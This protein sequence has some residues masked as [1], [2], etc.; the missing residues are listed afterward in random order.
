MIHYQIFP[1]G[2]AVG[3]PFFVAFGTV[4]LDIIRGPYYQELSFTY[5]CAVPRFAEWTSSA[6]LSLPSNC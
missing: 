1:K 2:E 6:Q 4:L 3:L 5:L